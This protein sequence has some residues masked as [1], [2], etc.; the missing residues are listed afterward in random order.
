[1]LH[2]ISSIPTFDKGMNRLVIT[3]NGFDLSH[4]LK[5]SYSN[6]LLDYFKTIVEAFLNYDKEFEDDFFTLKYKNAYRYSTSSEELTVENFKEIDKYLKKFIDDGFCIVE[7]NS[8]LI[9]NLYDNVNTLNWVDIEMEYFNILSSFRKSKY[10]DDAIKKLNSDFELL[11]QKL[12]DYLI[13]LRIEELNFRN[14]TYS[15]LFTED[16]KKEEIVLKELEE[17]ISPGTIHFLNFNYTST[18]Y[19]YCENLN[20]YSKDV[21]TEL[22]FIHGELGDKENPLIFGFGDEL[23]VDYLE[24]ENLRNNEL[25]THIKSFKYSQTSNY[26]NLVRFIESRDFQVYIIGHSCGLSDRTM[27]NYIFEHDNCKSIKIFYHQK[28]ETE[29]DYTEKTYNISR[30]FSDKGLMRM[31]LVPKDKSKPM[32]K[33]RK[34]N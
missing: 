7:F 13:K 17:N 33:V 12:R 21:I 30:H 4:G 6:F 1:M 27:L 24:F 31:K 16:I 14:S 19:N 25:F 8:T 15:S 11:K 20:T 29:D 2:K 10:N 22:N 3:G 18:I 28:N 9:Q 32:P 34:L 23:N 26:H 5:T